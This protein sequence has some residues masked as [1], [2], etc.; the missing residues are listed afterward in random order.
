MKKSGKI[1]L[2]GMLSALSTAILWLG[3]LFPGYAI[4]S[5]AAAG[6]VPAVAVVQNGTKTGFA[7]YGITSLLGLLILPQKNSA[8]WYLAIFGYYGV[9]K[10]YLER[11]Q[12]QF[13][14]WIG[15]VVLYTAVFAFMRFVLQSAFTAMSDL[16]PVGTTVLYV[17]GLACFV[18]YDIGFS[19]LIGLYL[20][21]IHRNTRK[22]D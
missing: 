19:R 22:G 11:V 3:S 4:A 12:S 21:R 6:V 2:G 5:A 1:A 16:F 17:V 20:T 10:S 13:T 18:I 9:V 7:V 14:E 8:I 15:K